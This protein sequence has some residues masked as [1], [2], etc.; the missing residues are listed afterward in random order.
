MLSNILWEFTVSSFRRNRVFN[1]ITLTNAYDY[2]DINR[3]TFHK[4]SS[5]ILSPLAKTTFLALA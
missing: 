4:V 5:P 1:F 3:S 2:D